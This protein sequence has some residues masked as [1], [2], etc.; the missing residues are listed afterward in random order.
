M[1]P[2][3]RLLVCS[4]LAIAGAASARTIVVS[5][6]EP[7]QVAIDEARAQDSVLVLPGTY[8]E[9]LTLKDGVVVLARSIASVVVDAGGSGTAITAI[10]IRSP[11]LVR[12]LMVRNGNS[13]FGGGLFAQ[14]ASPTFDH[15]LFIGN[16]AVLGGGAYLRDNAA[17]RFLSCFFTDNSASLGG[18]LYLDF[19]PARIES[20]LIARNVATADGGA[21]LASNAADGD[22][23]YTC[24]YG[25]RTGQGGTVACNESSPRFTNCTIANNVN[26]VPA[27]GTFALRASS[28]RIERCIVAFNGGTAVACHGT[29]TSWVGCNVVFGN[30]SDSICAGDEGTN[31]AVDPLFCNPSAADFKLQTS[32]PALGTACG[33]LGAYSGTCP[34]VAVEAIS[35]SRIKKMYRR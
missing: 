34:P 29:T 23:S 22:V 2:L 1:K 10:G 12:G 33:L 20:T 17:A 16:R 6:G 27:G 9:R 24:M 5:P 8:H 7:I 3:F 25:N 35:W 19:S 26:G 14:D 21:L 15:C 4:W 30:S 13:H 11:T 18:G 32:S 28:A 31:L